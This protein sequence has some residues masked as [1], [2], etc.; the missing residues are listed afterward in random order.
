M[1]FNI[2]D[3]C[4]LGEAEEALGSSPPPENLTHL[5]AHGPV[6][7]E[8]VEY[9]TDLL[10]ASPAEAGC[11]DELSMDE[12]HA[13]FRYRVSVASPEHM[14]NFSPNYARF[15]ISFTYRILHDIRR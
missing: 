11:F 1:S 9:L 6:D 4:L 15:R 7:P 2:P 12:K 10:A 3:H 14:P 5:S 13:F 8:D